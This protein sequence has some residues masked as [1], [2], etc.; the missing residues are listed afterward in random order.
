MREVI[1]FW[2]AATGV[3]L[4]LAACGGSGGED[5]AATSGDDRRAATTSEV[6]DVTTSD[7][8]QT[9]SSTTTVVAAR[10]PT[11]GVPVATVS[12]PVEGG[13]HG[14]PFTPAVVDLA[15]AG[16]VEEEFFLE[17]TARAYDAAGPWSS[18]GIWPVVEASTAPYRTRLLVRRPV[19]ATDFN[20][21]VVVEWFNVT[22]NT[23]LDPDFGFAAE[24]LLRGG[25]AWVGVSAQAAG[26]T[27]TGG[28]QLSPTSAG[29]IGWDPERYGTLEHPGDAYAYDIFSQAGNTLLAPGTVD[30]LVGLVPTLLL[31]DGESQSAYRLLTYVNAIHPEALVYDGF[32][33]HSRGGTGA[34]LGEGKLGGVPDPAQVREDLGSPVFQVIT[35]TDLFDLGPPFPAARQPDTS[36]VR[37]WELAGTAHADANYLESLLAQGSREFDDFLD[38][39]ALLT[40]VNTAPQYLS[41]H[42]AV[43]GLAEWAAGGEPPAVGS[44]IETAD[45]AIVRDELG[46][47]LGGVRLPHVEAPIALLSGEDGVPLSG[48]TEPFD[49]ATL[50]ALYPDRAAYVDA[51]ASAADAAVAAGHLLPEDADV[52]ITEARR[53]DLGG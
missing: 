8:E 28:G 4:T 35:E 42:A 39:S 21:T 32:L 6:G 18:D 14:F 24:E 2:A 16:Y 43:R 12:G 19:E 41:M 46:L 45:G 37:T 47:A 38:L 11:P 5:E 15:A 53:N 17:G 7:G 50:A 20:G 40:T 1:G 27:S 36:T 34:P 48:R 51:V 22:S 25:Y 3:V 29:L 13:A 49:E 10:E 52:L 33:I 26:V 9:I 44:P 31:A 30:P 23:D